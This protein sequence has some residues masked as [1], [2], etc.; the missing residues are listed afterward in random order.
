[1]SSVSQ[2]QGFTAYQHPSGRTNA[3]NA[4]TI[5][6][7]YAVNIFRGDAVKLV[8]SGTIQIATSDGTRTG[9]AGGVRVVGIADG[10]QYKDIT[11]K[12]SYFPFWLGGITATEISIFVVDDV[13]T[14]FIVQYTNPGTPGIT[15][16]QTAVGE[17]CDWAGFTA[18]GG[19]VNTGVSS[20]YL[21]AIESSGTGQFQI[22]GFQPGAILTDAYVTAIV[23]INEHA[24]KAETP[25]I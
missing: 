8:D 21:G 1:M 9:T 12:P 3:S 17:Q 18:P 13:E 20:A 5:T 24:Y 16:V 23:R 15:T 6:S 25:S 7:G 14:R 2:A 19:N 22:T 11:G 4:Y 10:V